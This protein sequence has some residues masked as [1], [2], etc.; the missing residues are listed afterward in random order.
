MSNFPGAKWDPIEVLKLEPVSYTCVGW[1]PSQGR[2][3]RN[4][5]A[6]ANRCAASNLLAMMAYQSP[7][8]S[9]L[10]D[11]LDDL[12]HRILCKRNHQYQAGD[13]VMKWQQMITMYKQSMRATPP[14]TTSQHVPTSRQNYLPSPPASPQQQLVR[15]SGEVYYTERESLDIFAPVRHPRSGSYIS[16]TPRASHG[17]AR[18]QA[19]IPDTGR[20]STTTERQPQS[21][22]RQ[23]H[24][25]LLTPPE[26]EDDSE[27][28]YDS[29]S[30]SD[31]DDDDDDDDGYDYSDSI[32]EYSDATSHASLSTQRSSRSS[33]SRST[34]TTSSRETPRGLL[35]ND[36]TASS[37]RTAP[38]PARTSSNTTTSRAART[39]TSPPS[40]PSTPTPVSRRPAVRRTNIDTPT[41]TSAA[42]STTPST[43]SPSI[44][45]PS[46]SIVT[47]SPSISTPSSSAIST[48]SVRSASPAQSSTSTRSS[49]SRASSNNH[50]N[51]ST[52][53]ATSRSPS[54]PTT[55]PANQPP[56]TSTPTPSPS[57]STPNAAATS[58]PTATA[59]P[60]DSPP[61]AT[62]KPITGDCAICHEPFEDNDSLVW[63]KSQC[64]QNFHAPCWN[65]WADCIRATAPARTLKC[66]Y[67]RAHWRE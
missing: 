51:T 27:S 26:S 59:S 66:V 48:Q 31:D 20:H 54:N 67:C 7:S 62:R 28:E 6:Q 1:A 52:G 58:T 4:P 46:P 43:P 30:D 35:I 39:T 9:K 21:S 17:T 53:T 64:G 22:R 63:C 55:T 45:T 65:E 18:R 8:A 49:T 10:T 2:R 3:C 12:A 29:D 32:P 57:A 44:V 25:R 13:M 24:T 37:Q 38:V 60:A 42:S 56:T 33:N 16:T 14:R 36:R 19:T 34:R 11:I 23:R 15:H 61:T 41:S 5:I 40:T 47:P 50:T